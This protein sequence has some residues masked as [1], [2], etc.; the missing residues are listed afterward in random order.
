MYEKKVSVIMAVFNG[1]RFIKSTIESILQQDYPNFELII[2]D[3][4]SNDR[5]VD[6]ILSY[7]DKRIILL[8]NK[9]NMRLAYSLNKAIT[10]S[11]GYYIARMDADDIC[12]KERFS[13]Q[14]EYMENNPTVSVLGGYAKQFGAAHKILKYPVEHEAIKV[15]LL[16]SNP[17]CHPAVMFR[18]DSIAEWYNSQITAG[19]DYE[20]WSRLIWKARFHNLEDTLLFYRIHNG[21]TKNVLGK[22]QKEGVIYALQNLLHAIG[23]YSNDDVTTLSIGGN[24]NSGKSVDELKKI[25]NLYDR[26]FSDAEKKGDLFQLDIL[27][28]RIEE[29]EGALVYASLIYKTISWGEISKIGIAKQFYKRPELVVKAVWHTIRGH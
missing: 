7:Q 27:K 13:K 4:C 10:K 8:Q 22:S 18:K 28:H 20:L 21:Q 19:Q 3:D 24:R 12:T 26:I 2:V 29:Q 25:A 11:S 5:T 15:E 16:F 6:I 14:V 17:M 23:T 9:K 1:E